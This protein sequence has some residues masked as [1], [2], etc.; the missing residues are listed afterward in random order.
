M[1]DTVRRLNNRTERTRA[2]GRSNE[3]K[4]ITKTRPTMGQKKRKECSHFLPNPSKG[5]EIMRTNDSARRVSGSWAIN[6]AA[7]AISPRA[8]LVRGSSLFKCFSSR[9]LSHLFVDAHLFGTAKMS[10]PL[11]NHVPIRQTRHSG[12]SAAWRSDIRGSTGRSTGSRS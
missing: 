11:G 12:T 3:N 4:P 10:S 6:T 5:R 2:T 7:R 1:K 9:G 8:S